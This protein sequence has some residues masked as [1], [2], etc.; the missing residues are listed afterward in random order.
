MKE[1][2]TKQLK[3][4]HTLENEYT[5]W[6]YQEN[7]NPDALSEDWL[8][9]GTSYIYKVGVVTAI[10]N[11]KCDWV[12]VII[13]VQRKFNSTPEVKGSF[14]F[15][16]GENDDIKNVIKRSVELMR[17]IHPVFDF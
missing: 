4:L 6:D 2:L 5:S 7:I 9:N 12:H 14:Y 8:K 1:F 13:G 11:N 3:E 10:D 15:C 16:N 17:S